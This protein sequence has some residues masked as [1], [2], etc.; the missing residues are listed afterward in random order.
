MP[1][2]EDCVLS[3]PVTRAWSTFWVDVLVLLV[4]AGLECLVAFLLVVRKLNVVVDI[5]QVN[6]RIAVGVDGRKYIAHVPLKSHISS[7]FLTEHSHVFSREAPAEIV[8]HIVHEVILTFASRHHFTLVGFGLQLRGTLAR[9]K[10]KRRSRSAHL[11]DSPGLSETSAFNPPTPEES[12]LSFRSTYLPS[13]ASLAF[14]C[15][16]VFTPLSLG[17]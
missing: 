1:P 17:S 16:N 8:H 15:S 10:Q 7:E 12:V 5:T 4:V 3:Y 13:L 9:R 11:L 14:F 6:S 2:F